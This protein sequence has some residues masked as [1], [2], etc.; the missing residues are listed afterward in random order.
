MNLKK[1]ALFG[2][3]SATCLG[4]HAQPAG[5]ERIYWQRVGYA[6]YTDIPLRQLTTDIEQGLSYAFVSAGSTLARPEDRA[7]FSHQAVA[8][9]IL[10][11]WNPFVTAATIAYASRTNNATVASVAIEAGINLAPQVVG[12]AAQEYFQLFLRNRYGI[13]EQKAKWAALGVASVVLGSWQFW[14]RPYI[15]YQLAER[16][17]GH[18][19]SAGDG[20]LRRRLLEIDY[21]ESFKRNLTARPLVDVYRRTLMDFGTERIFFAGP[22]VS[23]WGTPHNW[24][25]WVDIPASRGQVTVKRINYCKDFPGRPAF[26]RLTYAL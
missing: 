1:A 18:Q 24:R 8:R 22:T 23:A 5:F 9:D 15:Q 10:S 26:C 2:L 25:V 12:T 14:A 7:R 13:G 4:A 21:T 6:P 17:T 16:F 19:M 3:M 20:E 11:R